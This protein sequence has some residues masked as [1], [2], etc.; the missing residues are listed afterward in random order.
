MLATAAVIYGLNFLSG[1]SFFGPPL[2]LYSTYPNVDGLLEGDPIMINGMRVGRAK[3]FQLDLESGKVKITLEF[4]D[5]FSIPR[6]SVAMIASR[7]VLGEKA[8][9]IIN[10]EDSVRT[11][12]GFYESGEDIQGTL[13]TGIIDNM[14][15][16][17][18]T[19]GAS[20]IIEVAKL[21]KELRQITEQTQILLTDENNTNSLTAS[22]NNIRETTVY[23]TSISYE[24]DS[25][26][27]QFTFIS[28]DARSIVS[29]IE[30]N[31]DN[32]N[33]I[34][35]NIKGTTDSLVAASDE[36]TELLTDASS[37]V[38]TVENTVSKLDTTTGTLGVLLNDREIYDSLL[39]TTKEINGLL[40]EAKSN[41]QRFFDDINLDLFERKNKD[42]KKEED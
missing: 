32:I 34:F 41:P 13:E 25:I 39:V 7:S 28:E 8:I 22:I 4:F 24:I 14:S 30:G 42:A 9:K 5:Q 18:E 36:I 16:L 17:V 37:A 10:L 19:Q 33:R 40:R 31:N 6:S 27:K 15:D 38:E 20:I 26:A 29:N 3:D 35:D 2:E 12:P 1:S 11:V 23:L 21:A